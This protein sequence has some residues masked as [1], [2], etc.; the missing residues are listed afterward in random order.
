MDR[1]ENVLCNR[2]IGSSKCEARKKKGECPSVIKSGEKLPGICLG[3]VLDAG[4]ISK[5]MAK[6][7]CAV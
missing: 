4:K 2:L 5:P 1:N 7:I 6:N 3:R